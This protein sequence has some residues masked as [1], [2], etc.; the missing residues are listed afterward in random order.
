MDISKFGTKK[1]HENMY[2]KFFRTTI[3]YGL[4]SF[5]ENKKVIV[6]NVFHDKEVWKSMN[7][8]RI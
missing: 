4:K 5:F 3:N 2:N 8:S 6:E 1:I 7:I